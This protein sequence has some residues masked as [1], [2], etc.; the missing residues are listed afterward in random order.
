[1]TRIFIIIIIITIHSYD[2]NG[3]LN[4]ITNVMQIGKPENNIRVEVLE[5]VPSDQRDKVHTSLCAN[6][7]CRRIITIF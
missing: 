6:E 1:M 3:I 2:L 5:P 4:T 7:C